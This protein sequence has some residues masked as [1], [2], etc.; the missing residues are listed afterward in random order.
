MLVEEEQVLISREVQLEEDKIITTQL[1][2]RWLIVKK[3]KTHLLFKILENE[4]STCSSNESPSKPIEK[5]NVIDTPSSPLIAKSRQRITQYAL[6][7]LQNKVPS[8]RKGE[9]K[10]K[11]NN[12][13][14]KDKKKETF[15]V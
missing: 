3:K 4:A 5:D 1:W 6:D 13:G 2:I 10:S 9:N 8:H 7:A 14:K 15:Q 11:K 12:K